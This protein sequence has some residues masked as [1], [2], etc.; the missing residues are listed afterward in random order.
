MRAKGLWAALS[1]LLAAAV[2]ALQIDV[3]AG[4]QASKAAP[5]SVQAAAVSESS[6]DVLVKKVVKEIPF[7]TTYQMSRT[8]GQGRLVKKQVGKPGQVVEV[9]EVDTIDGKSV[10]TLVGTEKIAPVDEVVYIGTHG[11]SA[12]RGNFTRSK[13]L[14]MQASAYD[15]SA[16]RGAAAT[17]KTANGMRARYGLVAVDPRVIKLGTLLYV[18]GYGLALAADTGGAI[19]GNRI[20]LCMNTYAECMQF[21]RR[22]VRVHILR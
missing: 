3:P 5:Q 6:K 17:F 2:N 18:E 11:Y 7:K 21:G 15:P 12:G 22:N 14:T 1:M 19:K 16:G 10:K 4:E 13:V 20:D 8:V 9:Y